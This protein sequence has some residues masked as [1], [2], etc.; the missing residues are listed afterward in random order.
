MKI[1]IF[2]IGSIGSQHVRLLRENYNHELLVFRSGRQNKKNEYNVPEI[3]CWEDVAQY[4]A[5]AAFICNPTNMHIDTAIRCASLGMNLF[6]EKPLSDSVEKI[7]DLIS[8]SKE[9]KITSYVAYGLR[10]HPVIKYLAQ[11]LQDKKVYHVRI[12]CS[13]FLPEW[14]PGT[15]Y[16]QCY[17]AHADQGGGVILDLSH[18]FDYIEFLFGKIV[19]MRGMSGR[20]SGVTVDSEDYAD[21]AMELENKTIVNLHL[22]FLSRHNERT[23]IIDYEGGCCIGDLINSTVTLDSP[24][25]K[26]TKHFEYHR[27]ELYIE[28]FKYF[29]SNLGNPQIMNS[30]ETAAPLLEKIIQFKKNIQSADVSG[31]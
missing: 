24:G 7:D 8:L 17:S 27:D 12:A 22:N 6:I 1:L 29:F 10:F 2:G 18:E 5:Q 15:N 4:G 26:S 11:F 25:N 23:I 31:N 30:V 9:K 21:V 14:R 28:Q 20:R 19:E 13:S 16:L 3:F